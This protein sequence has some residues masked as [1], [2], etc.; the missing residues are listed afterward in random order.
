MK[1][2]TISYTINLPETDDLLARY[3]R[4]TKL[5]T[6]EGQFLFEL[7]MQP[8]MFLQCSILADFGLPSVLGVAEAC[9]VAIDED[10]GAISMD[11]FTKQFIGAAV[12]V[13]ME[14]NGYQKTGT[15]KSVPHPSFS[16]GEFYK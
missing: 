3:P 4:Y 11:S 16:I 6:G 2:Q 13:L 1:N 9:R 12:C 15:K 7:I 5:V 10:A 14:A 8:E